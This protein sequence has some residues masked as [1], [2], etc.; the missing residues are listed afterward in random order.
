MCRK[1]CCRREVCVCFGKGVRNLDRVKGIA[2]VLAIFLIFSPLVLARDYIEVWPE[3]WS[4]I[5]PLFKTSIFA[6]RFYAVSDTSG[7]SFLSVDG[8][9]F[10]ELDL[11]YRLL[12]GDA[13]VEEVILRHRAEID[14][15]CLGVDHEG[16]RHI[17]WLERSPEI[18]SVNYTALEVPYAGHESTVLLET[19]NMIQDLAAYQGDESIYAVWSEREQYFQIRCAEI[20]GGELVQ[21]ET[22]TDTPDMSVRP[23]ILVDEEG[24]VH[25]AWMET[26]QIGVDI[27]YSRRTGEGWS[28]PRKVGSGSVQ[29]IQQGGSIAVAAFGDDVHFAWSAL[30]PNS[31][32]LHIYLN[33]A[34]AGGRTG[35]PSLTAAGS[36]ARFVSG[37][38]RPELVWQGIGPFGA[39]IQYRDEQGNETNLTVGRK[40]A[41]RPEAYGQ[42][43]YRYVYWLQAEPDGGYRV[44]GINNEFPKP[45]S[46]WRRMGLDEQS[47]L[48]H[49]L[50]L[51][52]STFMLAAVYTIGNFGPLAAA[53]LIY[54]LL[55]R[56]GPYAR[57][58]LLYQTAL[59]GA[60]MTVLRRLPIPGVQPRFFG[61][62]HHGLAYALATLGTF[63]ILRKARGSRL[64]V[65]LGILILWMLLYQFFALI[66][67]T[68]LR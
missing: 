23:S 63:L 24:T 39:Q 9:Y 30:P 22:V 61:A 7:T 32:S 56:F 43:S 47:P 45:I 41:F 68:I 26:T 29:D 55:H 1:A 14:S 8:V 4:E 38:D 58:G 65:T 13:L 5:T 59:L 6:D 49:A 60:L 37:I 50:F 20:R 10:R 16:R 3:G 44:Y 36:R 54:A 52:V 62:F 64:F 11:T 33:K 51:F 18:N 48:Y 2:G 17:L 15:A 53:G 19:R 42:G 31:N 28:V 40:G 46:L 21:I 12:Q 66:P 25:L 35:S 67:Q 27:V 57:Q 34:D